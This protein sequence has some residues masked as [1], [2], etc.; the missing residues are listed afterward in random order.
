M[1]KLTPD[2]VRA[3]LDKNPNPVPTLSEFAQLKFIRSGEDIYVGSIF[4]YHLALLMSLGMTSSQVDDAGYMRMRL[5]NGD[6]K[7]ISVFMDSEMDYERV[8][9]RRERTWDL[10]TIMFNAAVRR[11][12]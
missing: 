5:Q 12:S 10:L 2:S 8:E 6:L 3:I 9:G 4:P 11:R 1:E 7:S